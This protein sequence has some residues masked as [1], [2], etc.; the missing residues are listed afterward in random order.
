MRWPLLASLVALALAPDV[1]A[2]Q[3][4]QRDIGV[5][6]CDLVDAGEAPGGTETAAPQRQLREMRCAFR[7]GNLGPEETYAGTLQSLV[8]DPSLADGRAMMWIVKGSSATKELA[9]L[10]QQTYVADPAAPAGQVPAL[11]GESDSSIILQPMADSRVLAAADR[12]QPPAGALIVMVAL[13]L[14]STSG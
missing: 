12:R 11:I 5:L 4:P 10:L 9:G 6:T 2:A 8:E 14:K 3:E 13:K 1:T 7:P